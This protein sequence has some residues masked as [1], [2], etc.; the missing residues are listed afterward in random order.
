MAIGIQILYKLYYTLATS[1]CMLDSQLGDA[2]LDISCIV[3]YQQDNDDIS[4][5]IAIVN[6]CQQSAISNSNQQ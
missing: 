2:K 4:I 5:V 1:A 6:E 3:K